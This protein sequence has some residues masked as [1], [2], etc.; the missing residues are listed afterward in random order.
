MHQSV[1]VFV[2]WSAARSLC[3]AWC[4]G[5]SAGAGAG[6]AGSAGA[7]TAGVASAP[8]LAFLLRQEANMSHG[9]TLECLRAASHVVSNQCI[10]GSMTFSMNQQ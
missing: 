6:S 3:G 10:F 7:R 9:A 1:Y 5:A 2:T 8:P 4:R